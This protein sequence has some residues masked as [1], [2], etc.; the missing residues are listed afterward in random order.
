MQMDPRDRKM[1]ET[2][3]EVAWCDGELSPN[4]RRMMSELIRTFATTDE[5]AE[6]LESLLAAGGGVPDTVENASPDHIKVLAQPDRELA[7]N[8]AVVLAGIDGM[9]PDEEAMIGELARRLSLPPTLEKKL[10]AGAKM[11]VERLR[12]RSSLRA[13]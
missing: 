11:R 2:L 9:H 3:I 13:K 12:R 8:H 4:E 5:E 1:L 10:V 6:E 7:F